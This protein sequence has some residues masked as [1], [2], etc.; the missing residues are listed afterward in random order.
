MTPIFITLERHLNTGE[1]SAKITKDCFL[2]VGFSLSLLFEVTHSDK[3]VACATQQ[4]KRGSDYILTF[5]SLHMKTNSVFKAF[6]LVGV[7]VQPPGVGGAFI[8]NW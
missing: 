1:Y 7:T 5:Q 3:K 8:L 6:P 2:R 4:R